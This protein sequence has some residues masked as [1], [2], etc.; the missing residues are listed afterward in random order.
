MGKSARIKQ[1]RKDMARQAS[2]YSKEVL[3]ASATRGDVWDRSGLYATAYK[4]NEFRLAV[5][6]TSTYANYCNCVGLTTGQ[7]YEI[8]PEYLYLRG[9]RA[10][11]ML[12]DQQIARYE[13]N[14][15]KQS[16]EIERL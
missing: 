7:R 10:S 11:M 8:P 13:E 5:E 6:V 9:S 12:L 14:P 16:E 2:F 1:E 15:T 4:P 3:E